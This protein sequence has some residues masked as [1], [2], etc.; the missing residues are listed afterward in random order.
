MNGGYLKRNC[1]SLFGTKQ[2]LHVNKIKQAVTRW[3]ITNYL[4]L[5]FNLQG[6]EIYGYIHPIP[7]ADMQH[8]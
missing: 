3:A 1:C 7:L 4:V 8:W 5:A 6:K 2:G